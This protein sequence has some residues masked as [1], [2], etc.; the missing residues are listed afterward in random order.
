MQMKKWKDTAT[1]S[2]N[3]QT[4]EDRTGRILLA[5]AVML[6]VWYL[7]FYCHYDCEAITSWG[8]DLLECIRRGKLFQFPEYTYASFGSPTNY[9]LFVNSVTALWLTPLYLLDQAAGLDLTIFF[10]E[11]WYKLLVGI[12]LL[13]DLWALDRLFAALGIAQKDRRRSQALFLLLI[14]RWK[15]RVAG[16]ALIAAAPYLLDKGITALLMPE[17]LPLSQKTFPLLAQALGGLTI[18]EQFF[19]L[20]VNQVLVFAALALVL[21]FACYY[22]GVHGKTRREHLLALPPLLLIC[23]GIFVCAS[24]HWFIYLLP[25]LLL[26]GLKLERRS[27]FY[28]LWLGMSLGLTVYFAAAE[29]MTALPLAGLLFG[30]A[31]EGAVI[32]YTGEYQE[33][34]L[35][36]GKTLFYVCMLLIPG[37]FLWEE[38]PRKGEAHEGAKRKPDVTAG[39]PQDETERKYAGVLLAA[40]PLWAIVYLIISWVVYCNG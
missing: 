38:R 39:A 25:A 16:F 26:M 6:G 5:V 33:Y 18:T 13:L 32:Q 17:Y 36:C 40:Q 12:A 10:Y 34:V 22:L 27:D 30:G 24:F 31:G 8:Y 14:G 11:K 20:E 37:V 35:A 3:A 23:F 28:L 15:G 19:D 29:S 21:C 4:A 2:E 1:V 9:T 7:F